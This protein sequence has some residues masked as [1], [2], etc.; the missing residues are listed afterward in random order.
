VN[1]GGVDVAA[2]NNVHWCE[3]LCRH[4]GVPGEVHPAYWINRHRVPP[5]IP[6]VVTLASA[7][8][9]PEQLAAIQTLI[10]VD[11]RP[12]FSV[13]DSFQ[14]LDLTPLGFDVL[15]QATWIARAPST[16]LAGDGAERL[17][18][19]V[20][21]SPAELEQWEQTW[22]GPGAG[23]DRGQ[24]SPIFLPSLLREVDVVFLLGKLGG[25]NVA[26]GALNRSGEV[27]G[28]SNVF[29]DRQD[30]RSL[31]PGCVRMAQTLYPAVTLVGYER[32]DALDAAREIG[33][34]P[35]HGLTVWN[36][37]PV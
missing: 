3:T 19:S 25:R 1:R 8:Q 4:H 6:N 24:E 37:A 18:W 13:K 33:F 28:I 17:E 20:V 21:K 7:A 34:E 35:V 10:E 26:T 14:C 12:H 30:A 22:R 32:G 16:L 27:V 29:S 2:Q 15:F 31:F 9:A 36:R 23:A 11:G 5:Y